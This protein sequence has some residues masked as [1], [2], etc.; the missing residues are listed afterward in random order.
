MLDRMTERPLPVDAAPRAQ[1]SGD[2]RL[3]FP[4]FFDPSWDAEVAPL[5]LA[6]PPPADDADGAGT[7]PACTPGRH[8]R[9]LP[10]GQGRPRV[11]RAVRRHQC[12]SEADG[13]GHQA[14]AAGE[15]PPVAVASTRP[16]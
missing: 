16:A 7:A 11:P 2:E 1:P 10:D 5:P 4:F 12:R 14:A 13:V 3:S 15:H 9:R 8:L 6:A